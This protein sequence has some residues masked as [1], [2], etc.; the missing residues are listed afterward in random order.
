MG[1][2]GRERVLELNVIKGKDECQRKNPRKKSGSRKNGVGKGTDAG[3]SS[4]RK[5]RKSDK[6]DSRK[7]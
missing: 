7:R 6:A 2:L 3:S 5:T 1:I 4:A